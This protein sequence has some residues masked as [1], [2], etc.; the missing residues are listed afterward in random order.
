MKKI[1]GLLLAVLLCSAPLL[2]DDGQQKEKKGKCR[3]ELANFCGELK[4]EQKRECIDLNLEK[5]SPKCQT[6]VQKMAEK[7]GKNGGKQK[8][9]NKPA[10]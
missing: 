2:A 3:Q 5:L 6:K 10:A 9:K 4:G 1:V 7:K 8:G